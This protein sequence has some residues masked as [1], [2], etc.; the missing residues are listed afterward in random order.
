MKINAV[1][2]DL[3]GT[4]TQPI[5]DFDKIRSEMG[6]SPEALDILAAIETMPPS[7]QKE[8][9]MIL[10]RHEDHASQNSRLN[11]GVRELMRELRQRRTPIGLL[12]R[13][14][15]ENTLHATQKHGLHFD[16]IMTRLDGPVKPDAYGVLEICR[17]F[18][19]VPCET[20]VV[21]DFL[22]DLLAARNAGA[23]AVLIKT[24]PKADDYQAH[25]D[26]SISHMSELLDIIN[27]IEQD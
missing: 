15:R 16:A 22:H 4:L 27:T 14:S 25:A 5:L 26:Y 3:D 10:T 12:T 23:I 7:Q 2:F 18:N 17:R 11:D 8:A 19:A 24:H 13:N 20:I 21:G 9:H 6:L 1:I